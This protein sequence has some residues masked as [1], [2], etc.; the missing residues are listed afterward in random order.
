[1]GKI[2]DLKSKRAQFQAQRPDYSST[3]LELLQLIE[4]RS[5]DS[6]LWGDKHG[7]SQR[8]LL[9]IAYFEGHQYSYIDPSSGEMLTMRPTPGRPRVKDN[10]I[11]PAVQ[12]ALGKISGKIGFKAIPKNG[13]FRAQAQAENL[14]RMLHAEYQRLRWETKL[15]EMH[16]LQVVTGCGFARPYF[17][18]NGGPARK[19]Y[20]D[21]VSGE[22]IPQDH[23]D[24]RMR[25]ILEREG[26]VKVVKEGEVDLA[27]HSIFDVHVPVEASDYDLPHYTLTWRKSLSYIRSR[28]PDR[29]RHV[30]PQEFSDSYDTSYESRLR[31]MATHAGDVLYS[32]SSLS[33]D[34]AIVKMHVES[35]SADNPKGLFAISANGVLLEH[36]PSPQYEFGLNCPDLVK[37][38]FLSRPKS[39]WPISLVENMIGPQREL[40]RERSQMSRLRD[41]SLKDRLYA[42]LGASLAKTDIANVE[43]E[44]VM[45]DEKS[46]G[47][48]Q[49]ERIGQ[50]PAALFAMQGVSEKS[51]H[52]LASTPEASRGENP[53]GSRSGYMINLLEEQSGAFYDEPIRTTAASYSVLWT[54]VGQM[55][56][57]TWVGRREVQVHAPSPHG[58]RSS[59][60]WS[61]HLSSEDI[62]SDMIVEVLPDDLRKRNPAA[63]QAFAGELVQYAPSF[64]QMPPEMQSEI[65]ETFEVGDDSGLKGLFLDVRRRTRRI[66]DEIIENGVDPVIRPHIDDA[67]TMLSEINKFQQ[68]Y[69]YDTLEP[70]A[71]ARIERW[72]LGLNALLMQELMAQNAAAPVAAPGSST[73]EAPAGDPPPE[74]PTEQE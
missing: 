29:G 3:E 37:F 11:L 32:G 41:K 4:E 16:K 73:G 20:T 62:A 23:I 50:I 12:R 51:L 39:Y 54:H 5:N 74:P 56:S 47:A 38:S 22:P 59:L 45:V 64:L 25:G 57:K 68:Q 40:N 69:A 1:M 27:I 33:S 46:I 48:I 6:V 15:L 35:P 53:A 9:D 70:D 28:W 8:A 55:F 26:Q 30:G 17:N 66:L 61:G 7:V 18:P 19:F 44:V 71:R 34:S 42:P 31:S 52:D 13:D 21:P 67:Q 10:K 72:Q 24:E 60:V 49:H 65:L 2:H 36:G 63:R 58:G 43:G 14:D